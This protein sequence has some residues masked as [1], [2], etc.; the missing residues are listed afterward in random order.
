MVIEFLKEMYIADFR[1]NTYSEGFNQKLT[2]AKILR[3]R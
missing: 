1:R 2:G 3:F